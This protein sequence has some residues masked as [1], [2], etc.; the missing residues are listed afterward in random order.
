M[1]KA[2][3]KQEHSAEL[4]NVVDF[5]GK[6]ILKEEL[7]TQLVILGSSFQDKEEQHVGDV[8]LKDVFSFLQ[9]LSGCLFL[10]GMYCCMPSACTPGFKCSWLTIIF[11]IKEA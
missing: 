8:T 9:N 5:Y 2:A 3:N 6:D 1:V 11:N 4:T 7:S 10:T